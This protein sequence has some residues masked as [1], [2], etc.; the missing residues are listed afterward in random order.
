M[1][2]FGA[3]RFWDEIS[4]EYESFTFNHG[5]GLGVLRKP[6]G[7]PREQGLLT[8]L[9]ESTQRER[10]DLRAFYVR[11]AEYKNLVAIERFHQHLRER[12]RS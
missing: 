2:D 3:W 10:E 5:F 8:L 1:R 11:A 6:G 12:M 9:F 7:A 4:Q